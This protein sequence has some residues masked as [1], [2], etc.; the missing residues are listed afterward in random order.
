MLNKICLIYELYL[1]AYSICKMSYCY[2]PLA[3]RQ[4][5]TLKGVLEVFTMYYPTYY[6]RS[7]K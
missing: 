6:M 4:M 1:I 2:H 5:T 7:Y 3:Y